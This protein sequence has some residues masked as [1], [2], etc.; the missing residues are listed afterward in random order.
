MHHNATNT[1]R[2][3]VFKRQVYTEDFFF[4]VT[5][6]FIDNNINILNLFFTELFP[7][8]NPSENLQDWF[9][10]LDELMVE[11]SGHQILM[12]LKPGLYLKKFLHKFVLKILTCILT[13]FQYR[14]KK[15]CCLY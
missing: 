14:I 15:T 4:I 2:E 3:L 8:N 10:S 12:L 6:I 13:L 7:E 9:K 11:K 1:C 5:S